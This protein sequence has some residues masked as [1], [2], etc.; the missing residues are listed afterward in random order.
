MKD[1][2]NRIT[3]STLLE[4][5]NRRLQ[6]RLNSKEIFQMRTVSTMTTLQKYIF[7][8]IGSLQD[9][10]PKLSLFCSSMEDD[11]KFSMNDSKNEQKDVKNKLLNQKNKLSLEK[12]V[13]YREITD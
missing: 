5:I 12:C 2:L 7:A 6:T 8:D 11:R 1:Y 10:D 4:M 9:H 13:V 3:Q